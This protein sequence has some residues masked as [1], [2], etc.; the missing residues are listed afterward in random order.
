MWMFL[1]PAHGH[2]PGVRYLIPF[3]SFHPTG[4]STPR[5]K[6][7]RIGELSE[8]TGV[9][10]RTIRYY[11]DIGVLPEPS[12][13]A[14]GYRT[15]GESAVDRLRFVKDAQASGLTL[16][17]ISSILGLRGHGDSTCEHV[18]ELLESHLADLDRRIADLNST[19]HRLAEL[20]RRARTL[21][22]ADC[23]DPNRCHVIVEGLGLRSPG[24]PR[25]IGH[26]LGPPD[27]QKAVESLPAT[28]GSH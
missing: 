10:T 5:L 27:L 14:N 18:I 26:E 19:R 6:I 11:E 8:R 12:R 24:L 25:T 9:P 28:P 4:R 13:A 16:E 3:Y 7:M 2:P 21:D 23:N 17:E 1:A 15:Y 20:T 22:H